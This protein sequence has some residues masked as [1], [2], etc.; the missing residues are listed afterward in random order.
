MWRRFASTQIRNAGTVG[1]N[2]ANGSP[3]GD[4]SPVLI[5]AGATLHLR[6]GDERR[7][8]AA[9]GLLRRLRQAGPAAGR[10]RRAHHR[11]QAGRRLPLPRLQDQQA[12]RPGHLGGDGGIPAAARRRARDRGAARVRRHGGH[13][14]AGRPCGG[15]PGRPAVDGSQRRGGDGSTGA[16][17]SRR[18]ATCAPRPATASRSRAICCGACMWRPR[19]R[20]RPGSSATG[21]SPM[22]DRVQGGAHASK[23]HDSAFRHVTG[24]ALYIDDLPEPAGLLHVQLGL[25]TKAHARLTSVDLTAVRAAEGVVCVLTAADVPG[26]N[27]VS[28]THRHDEPLLATDLVQFVG[29]PIFAVAARTRDQARRAAALAVDRVRGAAGDPGCRGG[30]AY[31]H[32][33]DRSADAAARRR[34][35]RDRRGPPPA[36]AAGCTLAG[37]SISISRA[38][39]PWPC[40]ASRTRSRSTP[41]PSTRARSSTWWPRCWTWPRTRSRSRSAAWAAP[42]AARRRKATCSPASPPSSPRRPAVPPRPAPTATTT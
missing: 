5:A 12:V 36:R 21:A 7:S 37:R 2:I 18:S 19:A 26:E 34:Q 40:R 17:I 15:G 13:A 16:A 35:G 39:S 22:S 25:S 41:R 32:A 38:R 23:T 4:G 3:I 29:Q 6:R 11:A 14:Q 9:R 42:S 27:D 8:P 10:V 1:G 30:H 20:P 24:E 28:P 33:G 31:G